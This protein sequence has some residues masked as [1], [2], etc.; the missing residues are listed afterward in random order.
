MITSLIDDARMVY[1]TQAD[2]ARVATD[3]FRS[4]FTTLTST[5][6]SRILEGIPISIT[7]LKN[8][9]LIIDFVLEEIWLVIDSMTPLKA[10]G[11]DGFSALFFQRYW[12]IIGRNITKIYL[13]VLWGAVHIS[14]I[15]MTNLVL[16]PKVLN[17]T[18]M[19]QF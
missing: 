16:I 4:L 6:F 5:D 1:I 2:M 8:V 9:S 13:G 15:N 10:I 17:S 14:A 11:R 3:Y 12:H 19:S 7:L 18:L